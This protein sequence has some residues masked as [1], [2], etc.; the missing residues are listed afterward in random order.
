MSQSQPF[1]DPGSQGAQSY[2]PSS[3]IS[4][5]EG[6]IVVERQRKKFC[7]L[8]RKLG[9]ETGAY[10]THFCPRHW[11]TLSPHTKATY[12]CGY[13][14]VMYKMCETIYPENP[15]EVLKQIMRATDSQFWLQGEHNHNLVQYIEQAKDEY[16]NCVPTGCRL[17]AL[18]LVTPLLSQTAASVYFPG[19]TDYYYKQSRK[20]A[21][22]YGLG[23]PKPV[24]AN[25]KRC[26]FEDRKLVSLINFI[27]SPTVSS[28]LPGRTATVQTSAG[29]KKVIANLMRLLSNKLIA[30]QYNNL[31]VAN[32]Q[33]DLQM[34]EGTILKILQHIPASKM[35]VMQGIDYFTH[36]GLEAIDDMMECIQVLQR[37]GK[38][39][40][41]YAKDLIRQT[42][43]ARQYLMV[44]YKLHIKTESRIPDHCIQH[45]LSDPKDFAF[46]TVC[47]NHRH[48]LLCQNCVK[49]QALPAEIQG[50]ITRA[51]FPDED[52]SQTEDR[53]TKDSL[54]Y[55]IDTAADKLNEWQK[56]IMRSVNQE[57]PKL[58]FMKNLDGNTVILIGDF[59]MKMLPFSGRMSQKDWFGLRGKLCSFVGFFWPLGLVELLVC[60]ASC[61]RKPAKSTVLLWIMSM[62]GCYFR[63]SLFT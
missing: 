59:A 40:P 48:D 38:I 26:R 32:D 60:S 42:S 28:Q 15:E 36:G 31:M 61:C 46:R 29:E 44:G 41:D 45:A 51:T 20:H 14:K 63:W 17:V 6:Q 49:L 57:K 50:V 18:S 16:A 35:K 33:P 53:H 58:D 12:A 37:T 22:L 10:Y 25:I 13:K 27:A 47:N 3:E 23:K 9:L 8:F 34:P 55:I 52:G 39:A 2:D 19:I 5:G 56:H 62:L 43:E 30:K 24:V 21:S 11:L 1:S 7:V 54:S 4:D